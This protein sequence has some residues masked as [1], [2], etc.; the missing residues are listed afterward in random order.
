MPGALSRR[1]LI[2]G[3]ISLVAAPA[4]IRVASLMPINSGLAPGTDPWWTLVPLFWAEIDES[5]IPILTKTMLIT[6]SLTIASTPL[7]RAGEQVRAG[8]LIAGEAYKIY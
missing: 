8:E 3:L 4:I 5:R 6:G 7:L 2:T 1:S